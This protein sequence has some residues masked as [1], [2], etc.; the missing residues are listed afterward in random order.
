MTPLSPPPSRTPRRVVAYQ[1]SLLGDPP[2]VCY[3]WRRS[4][5]VFSFC[6]MPFPFS[7]DEARQHRLLRPDSLAGRPPMETR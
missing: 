2:K 1:L 6:G 5:Y 4:F 3:A 7:E